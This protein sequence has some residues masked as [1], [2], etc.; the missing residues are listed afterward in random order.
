MCIRD[1]PTGTL[2]SRTGEEIMRLLLGLNEARGT[3]LI[4]VTH[5]PEVA[6]RTQRVIRLRDGLVEEGAPAKAHGERR[7]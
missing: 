4:F 5:D 2:D 6:G 7:S 3:T 1:R